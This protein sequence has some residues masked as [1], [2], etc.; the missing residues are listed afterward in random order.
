MRFALQRLLR[1]GIVLLGLQLT[2]GQVAEV[3]LGGVA[4][5]VTTLAA[6]FVFTSWLGRVLGVEAGLAQ[7]IAAGTSA[8]LRR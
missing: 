1:A 2:L 8:V 7:L 6:T 4:V 3:G 5:I